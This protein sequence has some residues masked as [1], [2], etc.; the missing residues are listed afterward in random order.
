MH[1]A[2]RI[3]LRHLLMQNAA[4]C[5]HPLH[6]TR[7]HLSLVAQAAPVLDRSRHN[8]GDRLNPAVG[9][10]WKYRQ[11]VIGILVAEIVEQQKWIELIGLPEAKRTTDLY[12]G[13]FQRRFGFNNSFYRSERHNDSPFHWM[14]EM[15]RRLPRATFVSWPSRT[16]RRA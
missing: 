2:P 4:A 6:I 11:V 14:S 3:P 8:I 5:G 12:A 15:C 1:S 16:E 9:M 10:P 13:A 7:T